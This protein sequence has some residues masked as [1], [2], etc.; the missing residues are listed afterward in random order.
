MQLAQMVTQDMSNYSY[1]R[2]F[3]QFSVDVKRCSETVKFMLTLPA[4]SSLNIFPFCVLQKIEISFVVMEPK[5]EDL[6]ALQYTNERCGIG[7]VPQH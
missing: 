2:H 1:L 6:T 5:D 4:A 7:V 3:Q